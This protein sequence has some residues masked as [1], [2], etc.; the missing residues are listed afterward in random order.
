MRVLVTGSRGY[1]NAWQLATVLTGLVLGQDPGTTDF[2]QGN[3]PEG[4][5]KLC[6]QFCRKANLPCY[7]F[8]ADWT[9]YGKPAG[10][11]RNRRMLVEGQP[12]LVVAFFVDNIRTSG[13]SGMVKLAQ[14]AKVE[15]WEIPDVRH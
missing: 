14:K 8:T 7:G 10:M 9:K 15:V 6:R 4:A 12:D 2:I 13:T 1:T 11:I 5:D 3:C